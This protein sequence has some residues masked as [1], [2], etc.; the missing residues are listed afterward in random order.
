MSANVK[1]PDNRAVGAV[2]ATASA[3]ALACG[4]CCVLPFAL[5]A[6]LLGSIGGVLAWFAN[7]YQWLTPIAVLAVVA[8]WAWIG[9]QSH[10]TRRRPARRSLIVMAFATAMMIAALAWPTIEPIVIGFLKS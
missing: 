5:P 1:K 8:G 9:Y 6:V 7:I 10:A 3:A 4:V 2:A